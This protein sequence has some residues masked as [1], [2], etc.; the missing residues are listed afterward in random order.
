MV[1]AAAAYVDDSPIGLF[2]AGALKLAYDRRDGKFLDWVTQTT[3]NAGNIKD[4][5]KDV[6]GEVGK[7]VREAK[8]A[9][10]GQL[11]AHEQAPMNSTER[12]Q[13]EQLAEAWR[14]RHQALI[15]EAASRDAQ[16]NQLKQQLDSALEE[17]RD[18]QQAEQMRTET[19][20]AKERYEMDEPYISPAVP[21]L[22]AE[23]INAI[24]SVFR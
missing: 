7:V 14:S 23:T 8:A 19:A 15:E 1:P 2:D 10:P 22:R 21:S 16:A 3:V 13:V 18:R 5:I 12:Q 11:G 6:V 17:L 9:Q 24:G 20:R 4:M